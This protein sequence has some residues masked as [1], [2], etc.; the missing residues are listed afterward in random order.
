MKLTDLSKLIT[1]NEYA[2]K[3]SQLTASAIYDQIRNDRFK[4]KQ[5]VR[6]GKKV[7]IQLT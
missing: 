4:D 5:V 1:V 7:Y 2:K 6:I 3:Y